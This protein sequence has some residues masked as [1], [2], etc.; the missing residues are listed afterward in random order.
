MT[1]RLLIVYAHPDDES[2]GLGALIAKYGSEGVEVS[3]ICTTNGDVG[4]VE[5]QFMG[6]HA[7]VADV[8]LAELDC[9]T[10][11]LGITEVIK[12]GYR[13]SGMM[14]SPDNND[15][16]ASWQVPDDVMADQIIQVIH[17]LRPQVVITFDPFG[18]Y[19][20]PDHIKCNRATL[21]AFAKMHGDPDQPQKLYYHAFPRGMVRVGVLIMRATGR[22]P[23]K[24]GKNQDMD[25]Q[26]ILDETLPTHTKI[27][28]ASHY[29]TGQ[30]AA[31]CHASQLG[32]GPRGLLNSEFI[33]R[34]MN[35]YSAFTRVIPAP[36]RNEPIEVD[37]FAGVHEDAAVQPAGGSPPVPHALP[38][39]MPD[40]PVAV[41]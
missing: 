36:Q 41:I 14:G 28:T 31:E 40:H 30:R 19:G 26:A 16:H 35:A 3:L 33:N 37:L 18:G 6:N 39:V 9:A 24:M 7:T 20:H 4:T 13:D 34:Q 32:G 8:R 2:F 22:N 11:I 25:L 12:F 29:A 15:P 5:S 21:A 27:Y 38:Q 23:R 1:K 17:R 10:Q